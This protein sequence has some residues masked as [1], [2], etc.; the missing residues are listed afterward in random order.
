MQ[1]DAGNGRASPL[2]WLRVLPQYLLPQHVLSRFIGWLARARCKPWK[3][4]LI[5]GFSRAFSVDLN[6]AEAADPAYYPS[7]AQFFC[8]HLRPGIRPLDTDPLSV[9]SPVDGTISELGTLRADQMLQAKGRWF[10]LADLLGEEEASGFRDGSFVTLYL[11]PCDYHRIHMPVDGCL[12]RAQHLP[13]RLFSVNACSARVIPRLYARNER[14]ALRF[15][16]DQGAMALI[17]VGALLVGG[18]ETI[19]TGRVPAG[20]RHASRS[21]YAPGEQPLGRGEDLG[22]FHFGSTVILL[23]PKETVQWLEPRR[24]QTPI[25]QGQALGRISSGTPRQHKRAAVVNNSR[26]VL[27]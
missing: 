7:F 3:T 19:W 8:R 23:Y 9:L 5:K 1:D 21:D 2:D 22:C 20:A 12:R 15:D 13:G 4:L 16:T 6:E 10:S 27:Q 26:Q 17:L 24:P 25:R 11:A 18:L 14:L